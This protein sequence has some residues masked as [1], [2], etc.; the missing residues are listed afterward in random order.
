MERCSTDLF[1]IHVHVSFV[2]LICYVLAFLSLNTKV[3]W[4]FSLASIVIVDFFFGLELEKFSSF[5]YAGMT[6]SIVL[7][8]VLFAH[9]DL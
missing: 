8:R 1:N 4:T 9:V 7:I 6:I 3:A 5:S 2:S